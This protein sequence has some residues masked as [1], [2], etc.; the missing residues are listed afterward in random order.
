MAL[1]AT[2]LAACSNGTGLPFFKKWYEGEQPVVG[3]LFNHPQ[4]TIWYNIEGDDSENSDEDSD[5][6]T[7]GR[8][9]I[10]DSVSVVKSGKIITYIF[11]TEGQDVPLGKMLKMSDREAITFAQKQDKKRWRESM[12]H[13]KDN[14]I[15]GY[16]EEI[17]SGNLNSAEIRLDKKA[18]QF[19][20]KLYDDSEYQ[21][22]TANPIT[23]D[24]TLDSS[25]NEAKEEIIEI[26]AARYYSGWSNKMVKEFKRGKS[27]EVQKNGKLRLTSSSE[28]SWPKTVNINADMTSMDP[29]QLY[30][31]QQESFTV[32]NKTLYG[33]AE[34][35]DTDN[36][37]VT[38]ID[39]KQFE[40]H[41]QTSVVKKDTTKSKNI[42]VSDDN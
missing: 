17:S 15:G 38:P 5:N 41:G 40:K 37:F 27:P 34:G 1:L 42:K 25:G 31:G 12:R 8:E 32:Y 9:S 36:A 35:E 16:G 10:I 2:T 19:L 13:L 26:S 20:Q 7:Y 21:A 11:P 29:I 23:A 14:S 4:E 30:C 28:N 22:P 24:V 18:I 33:F 6:V 39:S 3:K